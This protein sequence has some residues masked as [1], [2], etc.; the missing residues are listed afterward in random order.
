MAD[1]HIALQIAYRE[2]LGGVCERNHRVHGN[3]KALDIRLF[4]VAAVVEEKVVEKSRA[5]ACSRVKTEL[6]ADEKI[7]VRNVQAVL[8]AAC[9]EVVREVF[10]MFNAPALQKVA[11]AIVKLVVFR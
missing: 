1:N 7:V 8:K 4:A 6:P 5:G 10:Q 9:P 11:Y 2:Q 3:V